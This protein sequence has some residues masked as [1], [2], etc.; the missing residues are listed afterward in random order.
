MKLIIILL[1]ILLAAC[2]TKSLNVKNVKK[3]VAPVFTPKPPP[4]FVQ[5]TKPR[6]K[7]LNKT[8]TINKQNITLIDA[9]NSEVPEAVVIANDSGVNL[10]QSI[11]VR[12]NGSL[13]DYLSYL[14]NITKYKLTPKNNNI[15]IK[16]KIQK[17]WNLAALSIIT[18]N[19]QTNQA[20][21]HNND[22][23]WQ[24]IISSIQKIISKEAKIIDNQRTGDIFVIATPVD[25]DTINTYLT[26]IKNKSEQQVYLKVVV[27]DV[28]LNDDSATGIDWSVIQTGNR[29]SFGITQVANQVLD[30]AGVVSIG[31]VNNSTLISKSGET[32]LKL[33]INLLSK[34]GAVRVENQPDLVVLNGNQAYI[35]TGD[36]FSYVKSINANTDS[37][38]N[39]TTTAEIKR[40]NVGVE[41][42]VTPKILDDGRILVNVVPVISSLKNFSN[43]TSGNQTFQTPNIVLQKLTT[44][45]IVKSGQTLHLGGLIAEKISKASKSSTNAIL[46]SLFSGIQSRFER[47]EIAILITPELI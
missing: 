6:N 44:Q 32:S 9:I 11:S 30:E 12:F 8:I 46:R 26:N 36:E 27:L 13:S 5:I 2:N 45:A 7:L 1:S 40:I 43:I 41:L 39:I 35:S 16:S 21:G 18:S 19:S 3:T 10:T 28:T 15:I 34:Q 33:L 47:R 42:Q 29:G 22:P 38:G 24:K 25:I 4:I 31:T 20:I 17:S 23:K 37:Q 14:A